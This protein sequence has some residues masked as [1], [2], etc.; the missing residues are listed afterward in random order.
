MIVVSAVVVAIVVGEKGVPASLMIGVV[1]LACRSD[2]VELW[3]V[4]RVVEAA[5][6]ANPKLKS[7]VVV[8]LS[9]RLVNVA[10]GMLVVMS[11]AALA[12]AFVVV[13]VIVVVVA[14]G[15]SIALHTPCLL[16]PT[17]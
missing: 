13:L 3:S 2:D 7:A 5:M 1:E 12:V 11:V 16:L 4:I 8:L 6:G 14:V 15:T 17:F 10:V 9:S